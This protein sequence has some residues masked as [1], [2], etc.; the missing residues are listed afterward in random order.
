MVDTMD[1]GRLMLHHERPNT[2]ILMQDP[3]YMHHPVTMYWCPPRS[4]TPRHIDGSGPNGIFVTGT[5]D[6]A[7]VLH[8][9]YRDTRWGEQRDHPSFPQ[10]CFRGS[11]QHQQGVSVEARTGC[12]RQ[13]PKDNSTSHSTSNGRSHGII[14]CRPWH[15]RLYAQPQPTT[16]S[17]FSPSN[18]RYVRYHVHSCWKD[19]WI[20]FGCHSSVQL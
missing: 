14:A 17:S 12:G 10:Q 16:S 7:I 8:R 3:C 15:G 4:S 13:D 19:G 18:Q 5:D 6:C 1:H 2:P 11:L 20:H 9:L